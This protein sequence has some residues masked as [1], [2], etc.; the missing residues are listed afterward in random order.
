MKTKRVIVDL[1]QPA[2][3]ILVRLQGDG[4]HGRDIAEAAE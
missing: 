3:Q 4:L 2:Y 1:P